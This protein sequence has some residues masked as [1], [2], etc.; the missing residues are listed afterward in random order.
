MPEV[1]E[2]C[3]VTEASILAIFQNADTDHNNILDAAE[4]ETLMKALDASLTTK[5]ITAMKNA[6]DADQD[7]IVNISEFIKWVF[8]SGG[9]VGATHVKSAVHAALHA[10]HPE[11][12]N[13]EEIG[14]YWNQAQKAGLKKNEDGVM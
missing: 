10:D 11:P 4:F 7:G 3:E 13:D 8:Q 12:L 2:N 6:A 1:K 9:C 14:M 5:D